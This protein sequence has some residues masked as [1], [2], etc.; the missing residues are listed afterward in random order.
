MGE[1]LNEEAGKGEKVR[2][3]M[4]GTGHLIQFDASVLTFN[5]L[6]FVWGT[7]WSGAWKTCSN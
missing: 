3:E 1:N 7:C 4:Q 5:K 2:F 6:V